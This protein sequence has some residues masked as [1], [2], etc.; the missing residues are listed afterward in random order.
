MTKSV[1]DVVVVGVGARWG[2][3]RACVHILLYPNAGIIASSTMIR[4]EGMVGSRK[5][6]RR[7]ATVLV[8]TIWSRT[9]QVRM[10]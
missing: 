10:I 9:G 1:L 7:R 6:C 3:V 2:L 8:Y 4:G 5:T